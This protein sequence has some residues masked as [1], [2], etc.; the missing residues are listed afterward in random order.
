MQYAYA[1]MPVYWY[2]HC[3]FQL[4]IALFCAISDLVLLLLFAD[5][6]IVSNTVAI[7][8]IVFFQ[9]GDTGREVPMDIVVEV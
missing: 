5:R 9:G 4:N 2:I 7:Q 8:V 3:D 6:R 1:I